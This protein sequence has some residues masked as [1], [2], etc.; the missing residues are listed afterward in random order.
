MAPAGFLLIG[1]S[2]DGA[3]L[4]AAAHEEVSDG[5]VVADKLA[6]VQAMRYEPTPA[7]A[8][9]SSRRNEDAAEMQHKPHIMEGEIHRAA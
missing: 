2:G 6:D 7:L 9:A 1:D 4:G 8:P 3:T 5:Y